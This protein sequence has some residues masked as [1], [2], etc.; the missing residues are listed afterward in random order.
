MIGLLDKPTTGQ[1]LFS[2]KNVADFSSNQ[3]ADF[4]FA[5]IGFVFQQFH[6]IPSLTALE[7][8]MTPL[9]YRKVSFDKVERATSLLQL[10]GLGNKLMSLPSQLSGGQQQRVAIAR[11]LVNDPKWILADEPTGNLDSESGEQVFQLLQQYIRENECGGILITH[12]ENLA[13]RAHR[14]VKLKDG[15]IISTENGGKQHDSLC[16]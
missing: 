1:I 13:E 5:E 15:H 10:V 7:N 14:I 12:D 8:V 16:M 11:A 2:G 4:R 3:L 9:H 6:L